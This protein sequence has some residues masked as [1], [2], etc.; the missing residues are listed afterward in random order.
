MKCSLYYE[1]LK[2]KVFLQKPK[3][4]HFFL[5]LLY[6][7][8]KDFKDIYFKRKEISIFLMGFSSG[9]PLLLGFSTLSYWLSKENIDLTTIGVLTITSLPYTFKFLW[10]PF[11][12]SIKIPFITRYFGQRRSWIFCLQI[13]LA[14]TIVALGLS[15]PSESLVYL[16][17]MTV[18]MVFFS[19]SQ[20]I[21]VDAYRIEILEDKEQGAGA[22]VTQAGYRV[23]MLVSGAGALALSDFL[24]WSSIYSIM[25]CFISF[26]LIGTIIAPKLNSKIN[27]K[28]N[29]KTNSKIQESLSKD[30][31]LEKSSSSSSFS[32]ER[33]FFNPFLEFI[34]RKAW[35]MILLFVL[36]YKYGDATAG[37]MSNPF[38][39]E[40]GFTGVQIASITKVFGFFAT[41]LGVFTG[42]FLVAKTN[43]FHSL[44]FG[45]ILQALTNLI[46]AFLALKG[47]HLSLL[48]VAI[49]SDNFTGGIGSAVFVAY[50]SLLCH[51]SFTGTQFALLTSFAS[52]GRTAIA[53]SS[54]WLAETLGWPLFFVST[55]GLAIPGLL[56]L[57]LLRRISSLQT[58]KS[59]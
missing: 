43:I 29:L 25:A 7:T 30:S 9:L 27:P 37:V 46:F 10:A 49:F 56:L 4:R 23:G 15:K 52:F 51:K 39:R 32:L 3:K 41:I 36:L 26:G 17:V 11:I 31:K 22:A 5:K 1:Y 20:D 33:N 8:S 35:W 19:A 2:G 58:L 50:L 48:G 24:S 13:F 21:A 53:S 55:T 57:L 42:G 38:Y 28:A 45:G 18:I 40:M 47:A 34:Q 12:D 14:I 59:F 54:G 44:L 16:S 6:K